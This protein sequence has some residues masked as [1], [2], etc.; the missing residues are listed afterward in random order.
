MSSVDNKY[1]KDYKDKD[2]FKDLI[3]FKKKLTDKHKRIKEK[4]IDNVDDNI[5]ALKPLKNDDQSLLKIIKQFNATSSSIKKIFKEYYSFNENFINSNKDEINNI[6]NNKIILKDELK[7]EL[8]T[9]DYK[10]DIDLNKVFYNKFIEKFV[11]KDN[12]DKIYNVL[13]DLIDKTDRDI[14]D[15]EG[16]IKNLYDI[17]TLITKT[18]Y[19]FDYILIMIYLLKF[20]SFGLFL[21]ALYLG[22]KIFSDS[23]IRKVYGENKEPPSIYKFIPIIYGIYVTFVTA[24]ILLLFVMM[25]VLSNSILTPYLLKNFVVDQ[26]F[27]IVLSGIIS[28]MIAYTITTKN[29]DYK[30]EGIRGIR[31]FTDI[32]T[33]VAIILFSLPYASLNTMKNF[34]RSVAQEVIV[35]Y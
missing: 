13:Y 29:F 25:K 11:N 4:I 6:Y 22:K 26:I 28:F 18:S 16:H 30:K 27:I 19:D 10:I 24:L 33:Y 32:I 23:Y 7:T 2:F 9:I 8:K 20:I 5:K 31:A 1:N 14:E 12:T 17:N 3:E 34:I 15:I 21:L 35:F